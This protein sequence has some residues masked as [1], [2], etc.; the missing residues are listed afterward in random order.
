MVKAYNKLFD[1]QSKGNQAGMGRSFSLLNNKGMN[2]TASTATI[3]LKR[4]Q[5]LNKLR[6]LS[7]V[8]YCCLFEYLQASSVKVSS[9]LLTITFNLSEFRIKY[10]NLVQ[11][12]INISEIDY[13]LLHLDFL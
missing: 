1:A 7:I 5:T 12:L 9:I 3:V 2:T 10:T 8:L 13:F 4:Q 6:Y 11:L